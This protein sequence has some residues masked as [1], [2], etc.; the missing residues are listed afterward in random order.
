MSEEQPQTVPFPE[1]N[2]Q[3]VDIMERNLC[4]LFD[5]LMKW[6]SL[7]I[8]RPTDTEVERINQYLRGLMSILLTRRRRL[9]I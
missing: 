8:T 7:S 5:D 1:L 2:E 9:K 6:E 3:D 4:Y